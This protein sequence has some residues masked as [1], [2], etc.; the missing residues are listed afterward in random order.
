MIMMMMIVMM[1]VVLMDTW[2]KTTQ[3]FE[4]HYWNK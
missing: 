2:I 4:K 1:Q 3:T